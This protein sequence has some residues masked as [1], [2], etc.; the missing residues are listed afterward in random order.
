[1]LGS[2]R[3]P[4]GLARHVNTR[5]SAQTETELAPFA[6]GV[7]EPE[8]VEVHP[9]LQRRALALRAFAAQADCFDQGYLRAAAKAARRRGCGA[10]DNAEIRLAPVKP[11]K[12]CDQ[13]ETL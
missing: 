4:G 13:G 6:T 5:P 11:S 3:R 1:V 10:T 2:F 9:I 12:P 8:R 7:V